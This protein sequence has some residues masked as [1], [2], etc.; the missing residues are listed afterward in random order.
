[1]AQVS[2]IS[3]PPKVRS[4]AFTRYAWG[5]L[6]WNLFVILWG[7]YVRASESGAGC[8]SHWPLCNGEVVPRAP[9]LETIIEF[10]HRVTSGLAFLAVLG[11][12]IWSAVSFP[13][14]HRVRRTAIVSL[15]FILLEAVLGAGL[16]L[17]KLVA[18][19][20]SAGRAFYL[21]LHLVNTLF[22]LGALALTAWYSRETARAGRWS[23]V[24]AGTLVIA[25]LVSVTGAIAALGD[26]L[27]PVQSLAE[28]MRQD[29]AASAS[30]LVRLRIVHPVL[31]VFAAVYFAAVAITVLRSKPQG[32][33]ARIALLV[34]VATLAQAGAGAINLA[35][36]A[37]IGMQILHLFLADLVWI[38]LVLLVVEAGARLGR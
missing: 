10:G 31:A 1:V 3:A 27:F 20:A 5:V 4:R 32:A 16:V 26:T 9:R 36:L 2:T 38:S 13:R 33:V 17:L 37:P 8:G 29:A 35:L 14:G 34:L 28:G 6:A 15:V 24:V 22:L 12:V 19:D 25:I 30:F 18:Q 7:A 23:L 21:S 11:L